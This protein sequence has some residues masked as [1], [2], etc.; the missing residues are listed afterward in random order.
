ML[1][2]VCA[3][4]CI[5]L[6]AVDFNKSCDA[7]GSRRLG[8]A[9]I[10]VSYVLCSTCGYC[11]APELSAW[12]PE[13]FGARIYN[14]EYLL[15]D[16]DYIEI[17]PRANAASLLAMFGDRALSIEHLD[18]GGGSGLLAQ[19]LR[20]SNWQSVSYDPF[21]NRNVGVEQLGRFDLI[22]AFEVFEHAPDVRKLMSNLR[23]LLSPDG[24]VL[25]STL[26]SDGKVQ[27][28][29]SLDWWYAAPRNGHI[30]LHSRNSLA[31]LAQQHGLHLGSLSPGFH[32]FYTAV[33]PWADHLI[34]PE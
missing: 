27:P 30:S 2:P 17:R 13:E 32:V 20:A 6:D 33:P 19:L 28:G 34:R 7:A 12:T 23:F 11:F 18:Y 31:I 14:D 25:F 8:P 4:P 3:G 26:L 16:P 5:P 24:I 9:G 1:C 10:S 15:V 21:V 22:T 29:Q